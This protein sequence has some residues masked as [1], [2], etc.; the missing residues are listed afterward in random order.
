[1]N[2]QHMSQFLSFNGYGMQREMLSCK[3]NGREEMQIK[4]GRFF[5]SNKRCSVCHD[6][7]IPEV[8]GQ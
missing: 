2:L 7:S 3:L 4:D 6:M 5:P 1:M 8:F